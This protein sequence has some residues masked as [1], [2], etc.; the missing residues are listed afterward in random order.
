[1]AIG[2]KDF[3]ICFEL[4]KQHPFL[5]EFP[6]YETI[7]SYAD[8]LYIKS[9]KFIQDGDTHSAI[10]MLRILCDFTDFAQ[11]VKELMQDIENRQKFFNAIEEEEIVLAYNLL[12]ATD[13]L[14]ETED[15]QR[16]QKKWN[17]DLGV[18]NERAV[19]GDVAGVKKALELYMNISSKYASIATVFGWCYMVQLE[20]SI[21]AKKDKS[22]IENGIKNYMLSF[23]LQDQI[24]NFF[25]IFK[26][27]YRS[28]KLSL[29]HLTKGSL[30]MWRPS[31]IVDSILE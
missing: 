4:I 30:T 29:E 13:D 14:L 8:T 12:A 22:V 7:M 18:A 17:D 6:E 3:K 1:V 5:K 19:E 15:G 27:R 28:S 10:K 26:S 11:E 31:M 25:R 9:H 2:Q 16:L 21:R 24:E 23:G 20:N